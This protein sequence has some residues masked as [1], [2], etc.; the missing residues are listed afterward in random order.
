MFCGLYCSITLSFKSLAGNREE[1]ASTKAS[2]IVDNLGSC[3]P[4]KIVD[5]TYD[6]EVENAISNL[7]TT[8]RKHV[9]ET[10]SVCGNSFKS[11]F[12]LSSL[13]SCL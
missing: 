2:N 5:K 3:S 9:M 6:S 4:L 8:E 7:S 10:Y 13:V 11:L 12:F 1:E